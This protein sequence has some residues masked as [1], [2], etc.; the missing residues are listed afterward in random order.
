MEAS[1]RQI[2]YYQLSSGPPTPFGKWR[3]GV[4]DTTAKAAIDARIA[5]M[6]G[7]NFSDSCSVGSG[8]SENRIHF[9]PGYRIYYALDG[10]KIILLW[11]GEKSDQNS[12]IETAKSFWSDYKERKKNEQRKKLQRRSPERSKK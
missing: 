4:A 12:D 2:L 8:V 5:R 7:G 6:R 3:D 1:E 10:V 9:G 11:G